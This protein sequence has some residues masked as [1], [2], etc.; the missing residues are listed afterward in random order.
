MSSGK[1]SEFGNSC[2]TIWD[3]GKRMDFSGFLINDPVWKL[4]QGNAV[5]E[6][7]IDH[8]TTLSNYVPVNLGDYDHPIII[9]DDD[10]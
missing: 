10:D 9:E 5:S 8:P 4:D 6:I 2:V 1:S 3:S 7:L